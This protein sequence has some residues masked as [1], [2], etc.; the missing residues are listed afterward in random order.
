MELRRGWDD[1]LF[2]Y[3][4]LKLLIGFTMAAYTA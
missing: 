3:S 2:A 1:N 4:V